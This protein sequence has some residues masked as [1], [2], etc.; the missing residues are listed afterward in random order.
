MDLQSQTLALLAEQ[1]VVVIPTYVKLLIALAVIILPFVIGKFLAKSF[2]MPDYGFKIGVILCAVACAGS[3]VWMAGGKP[4][5]GVDLKGGVILVYQVQ[6]LADEGAAKEGEQAEE[7]QVNMADLAQAITRRINPSGTKEIVVR[8]YGSDRIEVI[9][10]EA[11]PVEIDRIKKRIVSGGVLEFMIVANSNDDKN[12]I[13]AATELAEDPDLRNRRKRELLDVDDPRGVTGIWIRLARAPAN[14]EGLAQIRE[15]SAL[16]RTIRDASTGKLIKLADHPD[17][18]KALAE[19]DRTEQL[20]RHRRSRVPALEVEKYLKTTGI[21]DIDV[22]MRR[23]ELDQRVTGAH[24]A[25]VRGD[26]DEVGRPSV[27]FILD[28]KGAVLFSSL[29]GQNIPNPTI[30][31]TRSLGIVLDD[32]LMSSP[33]IQSTISK[34]G[35][36]TGNFTKQDVDDLVGILNAGSLPATLEKNASSEN[37]IGSTLGQDTIERGTTA[38]AISLGAVLLFIIFYYRFAGIVAC[39]ALLANLLFILAIMILINAPLTLPGLAGLVLT[40]GMSVDANVLIFERIREE[41]AR[42]AALRMAIRNGFSKATVTIVDANVTT[43]ITGFVLY[44]IGTDQIRG[45]AVTLILGILMSMFTAIFCSRVFFDI[46]ERRRWIS[47]LGM[48]RILANTKFDFIGK[49]GI[50]AVLSGA[51][52]IAGLAGV[53]ARGIHIFNIDFLGGTTVT[54]VLK[55]PQ[56]DR[57]VREQLTKNLADMKQDKSSVQF[58]IYE[59]EMHGY[60]PNRVYQ[61]VSSLRKVDDLK[62]ALDKTFDLQKYAVDYDKVSSANSKDDVAAATGSDATQWSK[63]KIAFDHPVTGATLVDSIITAAEKANETVTK[64]D[65]LPFPRDSEA[66]DWT[67]ESG[68]SFNEWDIQL[69]LD[70]DAADSVLSEMATHF[71]ENSVWESSST[72]GGKVASDMKTKA[73]WALLASLL[74][75]VAYIWIRFQKV[76]FGLAAVAALIHDVLITLG[77]IAVSFWLAD[78]LGFLLIE[79]F[80]I[81]LPIVAAFLTIIGYSLNDTIVVFDR[82]R[83]V[84]GKSP[85]LTGDMI[86]RS[87]NQTLSRTILTSATTLIVVLILYALGGQGI[88]GF[89]F[90]LVVGVLAGT[91]SSVFVA[92][93]VLLWMSDSSNQAS[94]KKAAA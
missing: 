13:E 85:E 64:S 34:N 43:L 83:E 15:K 49:R 92:A 66:T 14:K 27:N 65:V 41:M 71:R 86:N 78:A 35:Q 31:V 20:N 29:T 48:A 39:L 82:I 54:M 73:V 12:L 25:Q 70:S 79:E 84:R 87:I 45:F 24:L 4:R 17:L 2:R 60:E 59:I 30:N 94:N 36:I 42:G 74:G 40:V 56:S 11:D 62:A 53:W 21:R 3:I 44:T 57:E 89:A 51:L 69:A 18:E 26:R 5:L 1:P 7:K 72:V 16:R 67:P 23:E 10:P 38:I 50:A 6:G 88:H 61:V 81:S 33:T 28:E 37:Q 47:Q 46:A 77:A 91:Y 90:A 8:P 68:R 63:S 22:L 58:S 93:P 75:I 52:I 55:E 80:K 9:I 32:E 19:D 76:V